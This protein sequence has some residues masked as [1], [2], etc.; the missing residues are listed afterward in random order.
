VSLFNLPLIALNEEINKKQIIFRLN[1]DNMKDGN[2][3]SKILK[4]QFVPFPIL[5]SNQVKMKKEKIGRKR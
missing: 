4:S 1:C 2:A 3:V 5:F